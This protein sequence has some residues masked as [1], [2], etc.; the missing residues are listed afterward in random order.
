MCIRDSDYQTQLTPADGARDVPDVSALA[1]DVNDGVWIFLH[2][3]LSYGWG[4][5]SDAAPMW[6]ALG[7]SAAYAT[8]FHDIATGNNH[9]ACL[10]YT[11][12]CV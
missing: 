1:D 4:G 10:L 2:G 9:Y 8:A 6:A 5:T 3:R 12:R 7:G 11:S